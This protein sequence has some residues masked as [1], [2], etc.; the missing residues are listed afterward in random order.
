[1]ARKPHVIVLG[2]EKGGTGKST[3]AMHLIAS[4][5]KLGFRV[6]SLDI[7]ARQG[8][9]TRYLANRRE[10]IE[11]HGRALPMPDHHILYSSMLQDR[12]AAHQEDE[13][14]MARVLDQELH[15]VDFVVIDSPG[16]NTHL[17]ETAH[18]RADTLIT[19]LNDSF[20]DLDVIG[21]VDGET[22]KVVRP[23]TYAEWVWEQKK[24]RAIRDGGSVDWIVLR[25]RLSSIGT[26]N[27]NDMLD[28]L[29]A[30]SK[31]LGFR[32]V[33]GFGE[34]VIFK[35]LFLQGLTLLDLVETPEK[36]TLSH[37]G[38][39]Q[40]LRALLETMQLPEVQMRLAHL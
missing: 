15:A 26:R 36:M 31:R 25:N 11:R 17:S 19:P 5:L 4:L 33:P 8:T 39:R 2:N 40:E 6:G 16:N 24:Q 32:L 34:R 12:T 29:T 3:T 27:K 9:L 13:A 38:A 10:Y 20:V 14:N 1:M 30:L 7:D 21:H 18:E 28:V 37:V 22:L 23:S 35:E